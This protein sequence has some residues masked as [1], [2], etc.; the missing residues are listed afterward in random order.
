MAPTLAIN[1]WCRITGW[2]WNA[3]KPADGMTRSNVSLNDGVKCQ[4]FYS[5]REACIGHDNTQAF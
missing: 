2:H 4:K 1:L 5:P 3:D